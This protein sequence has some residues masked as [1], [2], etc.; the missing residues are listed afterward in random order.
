[1]NLYLIRHALAAEAES[2]EADDSQRPLT[3]KGRRKMRQAADGLKTLRT[4]FD[5]ILTS[6][7]LRATQTARIVAKKFAMEKSAVI[8]T[9][10]LAPSGSA[11]QLVTEICEKYGSLNNVALV[12]H[13]PYLSGLASM[14]VAG[15]AGVSILMKKGSVCCLSTEDLQY[16]RC[17]VLEW[18]LS[19]AQLGKISG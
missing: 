12:G 15:D 16:G 13:E 8:V 11:D 4:R 2:P 6:P 9:E 18:L 14:L 19:A 10:H 17:A 7:Y 3:S 5:L 1:M